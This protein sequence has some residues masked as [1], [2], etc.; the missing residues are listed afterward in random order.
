MANFQHANVNFHYR[1][2]A[3]AGNANAPTIIALHGLSQHSAYWMDTGVAD[4]LAQHFNVAALDLRGHGFTTIDGEPKGYDIDVMVHDIDAFAAHLGL[5]QFHLMGHSTGGMITSRYAMLDSTIEQQKLLS[6]ILCNTSSAT[7]F[8]KL[9][10]VANA[11]ATEALAK[12]FE[13]FS[14]PMMIAG[15]KMASG[16]LFA[17]MAASADKDALFHKALLL[18]QD[19]NGKL[20]ADFVRHFYKDADP[21][22][23]GLAR[24]T[25][26]TL[27]ISAELD[28][29]FHKSSDL[30]SA[31]IPK[32]QQIRA[33]GVGH[34]TA[35]ECPNWLSQQILTFLAAQA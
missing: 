7:N 21:H 26:P 6:L 30:M 25:C 4:L 15:L 1:Y 18:M 31:H 29:I 11:A 9:D 3:C 12:S 22:L 13:M 8:S 28:H 17:G 33:I 24:I 2:Q 5:S 19:G 10:P 27:I 23:E 16:P 20:I 35:L 34:M 14:W 32:A